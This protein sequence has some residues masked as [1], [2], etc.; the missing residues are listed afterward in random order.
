[1]AGKKE[2]EVAVEVEVDKFAEATEIL[3]NAAI[4]S[5]SCIVFY[6]GG[7]DSLC[8]MNMA[9]Q[10]FKRV[11]PVFMY[12]IPGLEIIQKQLD[13]AKNRWGVNT[14]QIP[15]WSLFRC[16]K[17]GY[18]ALPSVKNEETIP[19][20]KLKD[21]YRFILAKLE[22]PYIA[23]GAKATDSVWRKQQLTATKDYDFI[24]K[25][26]ENWNKFDV[27]YYLKKNDIP[28]PDDEGCK[29]NGIGLTTPTILWLYDKHREDYERMR[30]FF[31]FVGAVVERRK[32]YGIGSKKRTGGGK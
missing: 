21:V 8:V 23:T 28:V 4:K 22:I 11:V 26:I 9:A 16:I 32:L 6:S 29:A 5:D 14:V 10:I 31:P 12:F 7:K 15:H 30:R 3:H 17:Y 2:V 19:D 1:M 18:Y 25:P 13:F 24:L 27:L 20:I